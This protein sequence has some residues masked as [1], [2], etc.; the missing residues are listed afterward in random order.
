MVWVQ[1]PTMSYRESDW[2][3]R[4]Q[5]NADFQ[6]ELKEAAVTWQILDRFF[7]QQTHAMNMWNSPP[8]KLTVCYGKWPIESWFTYS[9]WWFSI[10]MLVYQR[11]YKAKRW[12]F[13]ES[14]PTRNQVITEIHQDFCGQTSG[15]FANKNAGWDTNEWIPNDT[16][17]KRLLVSTWRP[18]PP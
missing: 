2:R 11:V 18:F 9:K 15:F 4:L 12:I 13:T 17:H 8:S 14:S 10:V 7:R 1:T 6:Q 5:T 3:S 16:P